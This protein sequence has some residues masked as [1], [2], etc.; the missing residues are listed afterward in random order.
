MLDTETGS[1]QLPENETPSGE[2]TPPLHN[3]R[4]LQVD[5]I[6]IDLSERFRLELEEGINA[7]VRENVDVHAEY[8][9]LVR[10]LHATTRTTP[11]VNAVC[12]V[13]AGQAA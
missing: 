2:S 10:E 12:P 7:L 3:T 11:P 9:R 13:N 1:L 8:C 6:R 4:E 5:T